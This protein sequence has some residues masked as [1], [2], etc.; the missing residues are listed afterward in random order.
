VQFWQDY[1]FEW[2]SMVSGAAVAGSADIDIRSP[3]L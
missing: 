2:S 1:R 3:C